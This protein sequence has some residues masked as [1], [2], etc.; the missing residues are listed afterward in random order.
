[1]AGPGSIKLII[2]LAGAIVTATTGGVL[3]SAVANKKEASPSD[4]SENNRSDAPRSDPPEAAAQNTS[5]T[6]AAKIQPEYDAP[7]ASA[8]H[9]DKVTE[10][11]KE[12]LV[13]MK[14]ALE[15]M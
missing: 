8:L 7:M 4:S 14:R 3:L 5:P 10:P 13:A 12:E 2:G 6:P 15:G 11:V 1:M 9:P